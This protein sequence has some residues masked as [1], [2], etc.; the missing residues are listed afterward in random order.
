MV[1]AGKKPF[2]V[3]DSHFLFSPST[4]G[5]LITGWEI[6]I[7]LREQNVTASGLVQFKKFTGIY[8]ANRLQ[9]QDVYIVL[10]LGSVLPSWFPQTTLCSVHTQFKSLLSAF[11]LPQKQWLINPGW[12][13]TAWALQH[14]D[15]HCLLFSYSGNVMKNHNK[16]RKTHHIWPLLNN[17]IKPAWYT[18]M[19]EQLLVRAELL[20]PCLRIGNSSE[21]LLT[22]RC[23][24]LQQSLSLR[25]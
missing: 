18:N 4:S 6:L 2:D 19:K 8:C 15:M 10:A 3:S 20:L 22:I 11:T 13:W 14:F 16:T 23:L 21:A 7:S 24:H 1:I 17:L 9:N 5:Q 25:P 12:L